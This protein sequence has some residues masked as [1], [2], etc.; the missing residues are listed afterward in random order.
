MWISGFLGTAVGVLITYVTAVST[1]G[2]EIKVL[3]ERIDN[4]AE[5]VHE[6]MGDRY[7]ATDAN[8]DLQLIRFRFERNETLIKEAVDHARS[9]TKAGHK[10]EK[11]Q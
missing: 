9:G 7:T 11:E 6:R 5:E 2:E 4:L 8:R 3:A 1:H 10:P